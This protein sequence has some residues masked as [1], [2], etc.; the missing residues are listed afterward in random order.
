MIGQSVPLP[1]IPTDFQELRQAN[2]DQLEQL[3]MN[4]T[5]LE[6]FMSKMA[7][8][9]NHRTTREETET[10]TRD[11][12]DSNVSSYFKLTTI[13]ADV[14]QAGKDLQTARM[15]L[16]SSFSQRDSLM[17]KFTPKNLLKDL[18]S[19]AETTDA[20]TDK[21][22]SEFTSLESAKSAILTQRILHHKAKALADLISSHGSRIASPRS[23]IRI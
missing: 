2:L 21:I 17:S 1:A 15:Q 3:E 5:A 11:L 6:D 12:A 14:E 18:D 20:E 9:E 10:K 13:Q 22:L 16:E 19:I 4:Q 23:T 7:I 8:V